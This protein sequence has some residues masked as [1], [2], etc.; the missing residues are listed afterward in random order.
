MEPHPL[1]AEQLFVQGLAEERVR[2]SELQGSAA[3]AVLE[4]AAMHRLLERRN[5]RLFILRRLPGAR[6]QAHRLQDVER[7]VAPEHRRDSQD[8]VCV[9]TEAAEALPD[10]VAQPFRDR[11]RTGQRAGRRE[12]ISF[13]E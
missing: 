9:A 10:H 7:E 12:V 3:G 6:R 11:W 8:L 1:G 5:E 13:V 4:D 2:E